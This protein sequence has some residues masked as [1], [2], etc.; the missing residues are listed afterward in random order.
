MWRWGDKFDAASGRIFFL[1]NRGNGNTCLL[2]WVH[3]LLL[4]PFFGLLYSIKIVWLKDPCWRV[5]TDCRRANGRKNIPLSSM[6]LQCSWSHYS[7]LCLT[8]TFCWFYC[9]AG[10]TCLT[11]YAVRDRKRIFTRCNSMAVF[12][13]FVHIDNACSKTQRALIENLLS[14]L[15][16]ILFSLLHAIKSACFFSDEKGCIFQAECFQCQ[17]CKIQFACGSWKF[18]TRGLQ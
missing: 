9:V 1:W 4:L 2:K 3:I 10:T 17:A 16:D 8:W 11:S 7:I 12:T 6:V 18:G 13:D 15:K 14:C 5:Q